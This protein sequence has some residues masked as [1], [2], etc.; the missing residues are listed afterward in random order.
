MNSNP[1]FIICS[2][3]SACESLFPIRLH[4][5]LMTKL[6]NTL[7]CTDMIIFRV[8]SIKCSDKKSQWS[9]KVKKKTN[10][11]ENPYVLLYKIHNISMWKL[12][13]RFQF[14]LIHIKPNTMSSSFS[15]YNL[16]IHFL[17]HSLASNNWPT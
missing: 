8:F 17:Y 2:Q 4:S 13:A 1:I 7:F 6:S 9:Q 16:Y 3:L 5:P 15:T 10:S 14:G 12:F 11:V